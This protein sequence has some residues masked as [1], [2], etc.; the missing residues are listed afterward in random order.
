MPW[1]SGNIN[2][3]PIVISND[4]PLLDTRLYKVGL[5]DGTTEELAANDIAENLR[6][7]W[8]EDGL[9]YQI[10]DEIV[11]HRINSQVIST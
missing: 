3:K 6:A 1:S 10:L 8:D 7:Q 5:P 2:G 9:I 4:N 11:D